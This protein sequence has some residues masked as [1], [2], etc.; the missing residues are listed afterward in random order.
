MKF[1]VINSSRGLVNKFAD[2]IISFIDP[3]KNNLSFIEVSFHNS[4][5]VIVGKTESST[6]LNLTEIKESFFESNS[7]LFEELKIKNFNIIDLIQYNQKLTPIDYSGEFY[8]SDKI[9]FKNE[10]IDFIKN[11]NLDGLLSI[12][13]TDKLILEPSFNTL[14][15]F[16]E[17]TTV[18]HLTILSE[19]PYG[20]SLK[21]GRVCHLYYENLSYQ[22][23]NK[24]GMDKIW[25]KSKTGLTENGDL[26]I[27]I[28]SSSYY[29]NEKIKSLILDVFDFN[30]NKFKNENLK[31]FDYKTQIE[32]QLEQSNWVNLNKI[33]EL[34][35][36]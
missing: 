11:N 19:F 34:N 25:F 14:N 20:Y 21:M 17:L 31:D 26:N 28:E 12:N 10:I 5:F 33:N 13:Y 7:K 29:P 9:V 27:K 16:K 8:N 3:N 6:L 18:P 35:L 4:F 15:E 23:L 1:I 22:V 36:F 2:Y 32:T 30:F 24:F